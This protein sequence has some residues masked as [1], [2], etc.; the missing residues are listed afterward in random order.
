MLRNFQ[1][2]THITT[3]TSTPVFWKPLNVRSGH[4][5]RLDWLRPPLK[6][7]ERNHRTN[8]IMLPSLNRNR[9]A[10]QHD[11]LQTHSRHMVPTWPAPPTPGKLLYSTRWSW[12]SQV[13]AQPYWCYWKTCTM[14][15]ESLWVWLRRRTLRWHQAPSRWRIF[16][17]Q[18]NR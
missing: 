11:A 14:A 4:V 6:A 17:T 13:D 18:N 2:C 16:A 7:T 9:T 8:L 3:C 1:K 12:N 5:R 15:L 10:L